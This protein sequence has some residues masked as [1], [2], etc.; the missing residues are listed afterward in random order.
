MMTLLEHENSGTANPT[1]TTTISY[2]ADGP[3]D[4]F[5]ADMD[6]DGDLDIFLLLIPITLCMV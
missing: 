6:N 4:V 5:A 1:F 3:Y 2:S